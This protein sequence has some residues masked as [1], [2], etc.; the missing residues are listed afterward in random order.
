MYNHVKQSLELCR[1][2]IATNTERDGPKFCQI[3]LVMV[4]G[5]FGRWGAPSGGF[6]V[7]FR[8][9]SRV[10]CQVRVGLDWV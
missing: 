1:A 10:A 5:W 6:G 4:W 2:S 3:A 7:G 8:V 9:G